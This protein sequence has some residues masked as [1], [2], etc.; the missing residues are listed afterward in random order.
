MHLYLITICFLLNCLN[1]VFHK[2]IVLFNVI[3]PFLYKNITTINVHLSL[4]FALIAVYIYIVTNF[5]LG[6]VIFLIKQKVSKDEIIKE[7]FGEK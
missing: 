2:D 7:A 4:P 3:I 5:S 1:N 6:N